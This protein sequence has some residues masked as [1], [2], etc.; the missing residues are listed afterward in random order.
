MPGPCTG[1]LVLD[2]SWGMP[3]G[4]AG[5]VLADYGAEVIKVEPPTGD[6]WRTHPAWRFWNRGKQS[7][8]LDLKTAEGR[9]NA[10]ALAARADVV[11]EAFRPGVAQRLGIDYDTLRGI[12][13]RLVYCSLSSFGQDGPLR[14]VKGYEAVIT[15]RAGRMMAFRGQPD[16]DGPVYVAVPTISWAA[17]QIAVHG[18]LAA[19]RVRER[20]ARGQWVQTSMLQG[21]MPYDL[22]SLVIHRLTQRDPVRWPGDPLV[23]PKRLAT[24]EYLPVRCK[25]GRWIQ[26]GNN[27]LRLFQSFIRAIGLW[28]IY[29]DP[30]FKDAPALTPE[31]RELLR[32]MILERM[33]E[34]TADEWMQIF[35]EDGDVAAEPF[36]TTREGMHHVQYVH[37]GHLA[38]VQDPVVGDME[39]PAL[40]ADLSASPGTVGGPA[41]ALGQHTQAILALPGRPVENNDALPANGAGAHSN[42]PLDGVTVLEFATIIAAPYSGAL[43]A[44][45]GARVIKVEAPPHGD[46]Y[47]IMA[48]GL[49][50]GAAKTTAGK[51]SIVIDLKLEAG[52]DIVR[53]L[54]AKADIVLHNFRPGVAE[55]LGIDYPQAQSFKP[56]V[57][58]MHLAGYGVSGPFHQRPAFHPLPAAIMGGA[59]RQ[60][61]QGNPPAPDVT[62]THDEVKEI[63]PP[64]LP[65]QRGQPRLLHHYGPGD[66]HAPRP[67]SP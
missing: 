7:V 36:L 41:P 60:A 53:K 23:D 9:A 62:L 61:G 50:T 43:L 39:Q 46:L 15:A 57:I 54:L 51:E 16:R 33:V 32:D 17:S 8:V 21:L 29:R 19:L 14:N 6:P 1:L 52:L 28:H 22:Q 11:L 13:P 25:D 42:R 12:N 49:G 10:H 56:D 63:L 4:L 31:N 65:R 47:R 30:R 45:L 55:R 24:L 5:L 66:G 58:Y 40:I 2:C 34:K 38:R 64:P 26:M 44:D 18:I 37:N 48:G 27:V 59:L 35:V 20:T 67:P 3:G